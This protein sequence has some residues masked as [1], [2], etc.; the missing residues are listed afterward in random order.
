MSAAT[1]TALEA[2][3]DAIAERACQRLFSE[4][5]DIGE[6]F[7]QDAR[8]VWTDHLQQRLLELSAAITAG[9][10]ELFAA[11]LEWSRSALQARGL[12]VQELDTSL[13]VLRATIDELLEDNLKADAL[14]CMDRATGSLDSQSNQPLASFL[15]PAQPLD[16]LALQYVQTVVAGNVLP[17]MEL[18]I[19]AVNRGT[20]IAD[21]FLRVLLPAQKEVGRLW[22]LNELS[23]SEE[24]MVSQTTQRLMAALALTAPRKADN[25]YTAV[26]GAVAGNIHDIGIRAIS[27]LLELEGWRTLYLGSDVPQAEL[28]NT[29]DTYS[30]DLLLLSVA[31]SA[32]MQATQRAI[33]N[34][35]ELGQHPV[36]ILVG[37]NGF[38]D[39]GELWREIGADGYAADALG[40]LP[41][42]LK[43]VGGV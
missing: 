3:A 29:V 9:D 17:G 30:A 41:L 6:R 24:H 33:K 39:S 5:A 18:V 23:V 10:P 42:A 31:L 21:A 27:Y 2:Q 32:Q 40:A 26:A 20:S 19:D 43:L 38:A 1:A 35:R 16:H 7:G 4:H 15:D 28:P 12:T 37:G 14:A 34:V 8:V 25:G 13:T 36:K 22:H 11:R